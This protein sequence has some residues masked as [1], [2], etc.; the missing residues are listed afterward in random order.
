MQRHWLLKNGALTH[1]L[2]ELGQF[3]LSVLHEGITMPAVDELTALGLNTHDLV[4]AREVCMSIGDTECVLARTVTPLSASHSTWQG[5]R[6]LGSRPLADL[7]YD[8][9]R[10]DRTP[11]ETCH[12]MRPHRFAT[13]ARHLTSGDHPQRPDLGR[14]WARRS[15]FYRYHDPLLVAECFLPSF[16]DI[17][18]PVT[19]QK[20]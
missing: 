4:W 11:F 18:R 20:R 7:L 17:A 13:L 12:A 15:V 5:I 14:L 9:R 2:R 1:G 6:G 10:I 3:S 19:P 8:D 16:W